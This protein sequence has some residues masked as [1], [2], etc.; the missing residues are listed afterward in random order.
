MRALVQRVTKASVSVDGNTVGSIQK[1][2]CIFV[3]VTHSDKEETVK[4]LAEKLLNL[5][6]FEDSSG[7][8]NLSTLDIGSEILVIS[9][10]TLY[11]DAR[12]GRRPSWVASAPAEVAEPLIESLVAYLRSE[13]IHVETGEFQKFMNVELINSGPSTLIIDID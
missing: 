9:Q 11:G 4:K 13:Q 12:K 3:G 2:L 10:F 1:G 7:K 5:R 8:M 6:I